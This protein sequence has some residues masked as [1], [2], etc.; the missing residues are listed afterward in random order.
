VNALTV[1]TNRAILRHGSFV[2]V[3]RR[4]RLTLTEV[5]R[6]SLGALDDEY[7]QFVLYRLREAAR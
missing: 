2:A 7:A 1:E 5:L 6:A 4:T 3:A